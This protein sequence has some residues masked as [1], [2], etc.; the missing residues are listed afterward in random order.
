MS[1]IVPGN[2]VYRYWG[3]TSGVHIQGVSTAVLLS[4]WMFGY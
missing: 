4:Q 1:L 3:S 2:C